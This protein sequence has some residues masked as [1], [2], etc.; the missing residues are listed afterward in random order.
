MNAAPEVLT[1]EAY[2]CEPGDVLFGTSGKVVIE[3]VLF[4]AADVGRWLLIDR[5]GRIIARKLTGQ[6]FQIIRGG[7]SM[8]DTPGSG[9][10]RPSLSLV[11]R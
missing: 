7:P 2:Q 9:L 10:L 11:T 1:V 5:L 6:T 4:D 8:D 3:S